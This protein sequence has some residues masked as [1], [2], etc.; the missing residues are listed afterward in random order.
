M[1]IYVL[2][3]NKSISTP[4]VTN[5]GFP[6]ALRCYCKFSFHLKHANPLSFED[7]IIRITN[8]ENKSTMQAI[9]KYVD[10]LTI[11]RSPPEKLSSCN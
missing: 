6:E 2:S 3:V 4:L 9:A 7:S 8:L 10:T 1:I 11:G 5:K